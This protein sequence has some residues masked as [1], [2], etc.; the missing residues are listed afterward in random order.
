MKKR[1]YQNQSPDIHRYEKWAFNTLMRTY[2]TSLLEALSEPFVRTKNHEDLEIPTKTCIPFSRK[3]FISVNGNIF[4]CERIGNEFDF[5]R[6]S[7]GKVEIDIDC[8]V[9]QYNQILK[10]I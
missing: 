10:R 8:V 6:I 9:S 3:I 7:D 4:P 1:E 2:S 5:G